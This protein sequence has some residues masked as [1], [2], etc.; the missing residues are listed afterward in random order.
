MI[1]YKLS[2]IAQKDLVDIRDYCLE[3]GG[4]RDARKI[5]VTLV[6]AFRTL[7]KNPR[8]GHRREDLAEDR[9]VL[10]W[11][12]HNYLIIYRPDRKPI[13]VLTIIRG[14]RDVQALLERIEL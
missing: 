7:A 6:N 8:I 14:T 1:R 12:V 3:Q 10:F 9:P 13:E 4:T 2:R 11:P 5:L